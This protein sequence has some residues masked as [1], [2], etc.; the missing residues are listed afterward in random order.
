M[1]VDTSAMH[2]PLYAPERDGT[3]WVPSLDTALRLARKVLDEKSTANIHDPEAM[4]RAAVS[5][6]LRLRELVAALDE[7]GA[8]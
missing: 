1:S 3:A 8:R 4:L 5:L 7:E 6:E 2:T